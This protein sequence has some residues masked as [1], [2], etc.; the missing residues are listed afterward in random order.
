MRAR[1][2]RRWRR[3]KRSDITPCRRLPRSPSTESRALS[4]GQTSSPTFPASTATTEPIDRKRRSRDYFWYSP[5]LYETLKDK[6]ADVVVTP[7]DEAEVVRVA[8]ACAKHR[9]PLTV[10]GGA[11]GNYGQCVPLQGGVVL[12]MACAQSHRMA[13]TRTRPR[14][15]RSKAIR[16]RRRDPAQRLRI[17]H[18]SLDQAFRR[19][20]AALSPAAAAGSAASPSAACA[21]RATSLRR[22][23]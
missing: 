15:G 12:D 17:A 9:M 23:S 6:V 1:R 13:E 2:S 19:K 10:R 7:R 22:A 16:H 3:S 8:A 4:A 11:T 21:S 20:S 18:A 5:I 14:R